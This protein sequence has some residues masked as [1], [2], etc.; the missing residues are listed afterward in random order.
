MST[1]EYNTMEDLNLDSLSAPELLKVV[2]VNT[3]DEQEKTLDE[4]DL[5]APRLL[6]VVPIEL[7]TE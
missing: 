5:S 6:S 7:D 2:P 3:E 4:E 1:L